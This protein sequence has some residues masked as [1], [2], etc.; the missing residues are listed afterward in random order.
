MTIEEMYELLT[1]ENKEYINRQIETL[2][3]LQLDHQ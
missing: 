2:I 3:A 1:E